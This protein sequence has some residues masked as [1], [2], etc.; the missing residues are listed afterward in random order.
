MSDAENEDSGEN[1]PIFNIVAGILLAAVSLWLLFVTIPNNVGQAAGKNDISPSLFPTM[2]A[3]LLFGL[4]ISLVA[5]HAP[6]LRKRG[7]SSGDQNG[8][9]VIAQF[10]IWMLVAA[11]AYVGLKTIGFYVVGTTVIAIAALACG[12]RNYLLIGGLAL[13]V[14]VIT[15]QFAW[16]LFQVQLP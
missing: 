14:P 8:L 3:W 10:A 1:P 5:L 4:S 16:I 7:V 13:A 11:L 15:S 2:A 9:W 6:K 12:Y